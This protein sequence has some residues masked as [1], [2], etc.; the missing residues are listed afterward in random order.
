MELILATSNK[1]KIEELKML[2]SPYNI[3]IKTMQDINYVDDIDETGTTYAENAAIK[4]RTIHSITGKAV[5]SDDGGIEIDYLNGEPGIFSHRWAGEN[6]SDEDRINKVISKLKDVPQEKRTACYR[7]ALCFISE[8][9]QEFISEGALKGVIAT[10]PRGINGISYDRL[11]I[12]PLGKAVSE[13]T[14]DEKNLTSHRGIAFRNLINSLSESGIILPSMGLTLVR[15]TE[16][17]LSAIENFKAEM[18]QNNSTI[19]GGSGLKK[20]STSDWIKEKENLRYPE[21]CP[22][23]KTTA[24]TFLG[25]IN[26]EVIGVIDIRHKL[27]NDILKIY[28]GNIGY[29]VKPSKRNNGYATEMLRQV[30]VYCQNVLGMTKVLVCCAN[31]YSEKV[32]IANGGVFESECELNEEIIRRYW[33][34]L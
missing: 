19:C 14:M 6:A 7:G 1:G 22:K 28:G 21:T 27:T 34:N 4:A 5:L 9:G 15:P 12:T 8:S 11:F 24:D 3:K 23:D 33:I 26:N 18:I 2:L 29:S 20:S 31:S 32:V 17:Y 13:L 10:E 25:V 30:L 16:E